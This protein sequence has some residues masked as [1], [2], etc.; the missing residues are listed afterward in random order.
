MRKRRSSEPK[1]FAKDP[2]QARTDQIRTPVSRSLVW[3]TLLLCLSCKQ[4]GK[5][6]LHESWRSLD[7]GPAACRLSCRKAGYLER[8]P[9][10]IGMLSPW[11]L[12]RNAESQPRPTRLESALST[13]SLD[14]LS[15]HK[16]SG[17]VCLGLS[18]QPFKR[19][20]YHSQEGWLGSSS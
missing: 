15:V 6:T 2:M 11:E 8:G 4:I 7:V 1:Q 18:L 13:S 3:Q 14:D 19:N 16:S 17:N 10:P 20:F 9:P 5:A 12:V